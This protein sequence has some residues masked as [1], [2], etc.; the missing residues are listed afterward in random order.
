MQMAEVQEGK[1]NKSTFQ[2]LTHEISTNFPITKATHRD[3]PNYKVWG[4]YSTFLL[5]ELQN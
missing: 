5:E 1:T 3:E 2:A 4:K